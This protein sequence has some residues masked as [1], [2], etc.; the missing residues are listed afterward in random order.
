M[1]ASK[2]EFMP[3]G[4]VWGAV[5][6][7][8]KA[9]GNPDVAVA[10]AP[11]GAVAAAMY[12]SNRVVAAPVIVGRRHLL[13]TGGRV[14]AVLSAAFFGRRCSST[15]CILS[16]PGISRTTRSTVS[17]AAHGHGSFAVHSC[18]CGSTSGAFF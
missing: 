14:G 8:I 9:S 3:G 7:G 12:T 17:A 4:F 15:H 16:F 1:V 5:R 10:V 18:R 11:G 13:S 2:M 6:A